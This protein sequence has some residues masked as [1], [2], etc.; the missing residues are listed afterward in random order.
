MNVR[1]IFRTALRSLTI[2]PMRSMLSILG[3]I[4]GI[5]SV[6]ALIAMGEGVRNQITKEVKDLGTN[7]LVV[8][9][10]EPVS[11][12]EGISAAQ[13]QMLSQPNLGSS[14]LTVQDVETVRASDHIEDAYPMIQMAYEIEAVEDRGGEVKTTHTFVKGTDGHYIE[15]NKVQVAYGR[16]LEDDDA[17]K[18]GKDGKGDSEEEEVGECVLGTLA[19]QALFDSIEED[20]LG[21]MISIK[22]ADPEAIDPENPTVSPTR[23]MDFEV[24][25]VMEERRKT[26]FNNPNLELY[27]PIEDAQ[28]LAGGFSDRVLEINA[29]VDSEEN[30][31]AAMESMEEAIFDNHK[32][33]NPDL[34][35]ADFNIQDQEDLMD[36]YQF[37]F[38]VLNALVFGVAAISLLTGGIGVANIMYVSVKERTKEIGVRLAQGASKRMIILQFLF[39]SVLLCLVGA[40]IGI[41][42]GL[43]AALLINLSVLP[44]TPTWSGVLVAF[45]AAFIVGVLAGVFP[46][47]QATKVEITE[48]LRSEF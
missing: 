9:S 44:A 42:L 1:E 36:T 10:G 18:K 46:A 17:E 47:R 31:Q 12:T 7:L 39:E 38:D 41:P 16:F 37:I 21:E 34:V 20:V 28:V 6:I 8:R 19:A 29:A 26:V 13:M 32:A 23:R 22:Y 15:L 27:I 33:E 30:L 3:V 11:E 43:V 14:T 25:G 5:A 40:L 2:N 45:L 48:A 24:V 4:I 35:R